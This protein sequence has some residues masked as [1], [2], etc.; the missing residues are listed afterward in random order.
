MDTALDVLV[1]RA[2][3]LAAIGG[4]LDAAAAGRGGLLY[5]EGPP[6]IGKTALMSAAT[7]SAAARGMRVL[8]ARGGELE[9]DFSHGVVRQLFEA[10][11]LAA[12][13]DE[14]D[15]LLAGAA[16]PA[17]PVVGL[18]GPSTATDEH[19][20]LHGLYWLCMNLAADDPLLL[21]VDDA[22]WADAAS[23]R[24]VAYLARRLDDAPVLLAVAARPAEPDTDRAL[25]DAVAAGAHP[26]VRP[27]PLTVEGTRALIARRF[28]AAVDEFGRACHEVT[29]GN[30][31]LLR[32]LADT[33]HREGVPPDE[34]GAGRVRELGPPS[35]TASV[36]RRLHR[37]PP[38]A[39]RL[40]RAVAVLGTATP[41]RHAAAL[42]ELDLA[43]AARCADALAAA[44]IL[45]PAGPLDF[46]HPIVRRA[47]YD[48]IPAAER[49]LAHATAAR[50]L[51]EAGAD[52]ESVAPHAL[53]GE[54][55]GDAAVVDLLRLAAARS[56]DRGDP[57]AAMTY[58]RRA[59]AE[60][61]S[62]Q[63]RPAVARELGRAGVT[64]GDPEGVAHLRE[65]LDATSD[66]LASAL[67]ARELATGLVT[68][69]R[70]GEAVQALERAVASLPETATDLGLQLRAE[71]ATVARL[72]PSTRLVGIRHADL[73]PPG[74]PGTTR[75]QRAALASLALH[76]LVTGAPAAEVGPL[77][78]RALAVGS[79]GEGAV[80]T[81]LVYDALAALWATEDV[82]EATRA[83]DAALAGARRCGSVIAF[84]RGSTFR[85]QLRLRLGALPEA[86]S[87]ARTG[88]EV[89]DPDWPIERMA[90]G[91]LIEALVDR[92]RLDEAERELVARGGAG[93]LPYTFMADI[94]LWARCRLRMAQG[95][96][97][98]AVADLR[99]FERREE[100]WPGRSP[101]WFPYRS[102]LALALL[103]G[104]D[105]V[106]ARQ[107]A[108]EEVERA[109]RWGT[110]GV[111]GAALR[112]S[113]LVE[114]G[115]TGVETLG[116]AVDVLADSPAR[117]EHARAV[118]DLG[119][120]LRR[121][122]RRAAARDVL[123]DGLDLASRCGADA[124]AERARDELRLAG[125]RPRRD[126]RTG[127]AA[128]TA[129]ELRVARMARAGM[130]NR[131]IAQALFVTLRTVQLHLTH[132]YQKL[133][134]T[135]REELD[136]ALGEGKTLRPT[137]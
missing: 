90:L 133:G 124:L 63:V 8:T 127:P 125:A 134:I 97:A 14:R 32:E 52:A 10:T 93:E 95:R 70:Y 4:R 86:E 13:P 88:L 59:L 126:R 77:A 18:A 92:G 107:L 112:V 62:P 113:A 122:G 36:R 68:V 24:F 49:S 29:G 39:D 43:T 129:A 19:S 78:A 11:L 89:S 119:A 79:L 104:D 65:A 54:P 115:E 110:R 22:H 131:E 132:G 114:G 105:P 60:P 45:A 25:L 98:E 136:A 69:G 82:A 130:T 73:L 5:V 21:V 120:A 75:A 116:R 99:E 20:V 7:R 58:L 51:G 9:R 37:L 12:G 102:L 53:A 74:L 128:L 121:A 2:G 28:P 85:A 106:A 61:P 57:V 44:D 35:V 16:C 117:L 66:P 23:L 15:A 108:A 137:P 81:I 109:H 87:D 38:E 83:H 40:A 76:R 33:L 71:L 72:H 101:A 100:P 64:A 135:S 42:A 111:V 47:V 6:G 118:T 84:A 56:L 41:L 48:A 96:L 123:A 30:L 1:E 26:V 17:G 80:E 46:V 27:A 3:E 67:I 31:F 94:L 55:R 50:L 91:A 103:A 34:R